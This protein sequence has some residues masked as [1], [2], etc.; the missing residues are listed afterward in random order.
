[1]LFW[2]VVLASLIVIPGVLFATGMGMIFWVGGLA[3]GPQESR[4]PK[5]IAGWLAM[6]WVL[7]SASG[8]FGVVPLWRAWHAGDETFEGGLQL[9]VDWLGVIGGI[10]GAIAA[11]RAIGAKGRRR[12]P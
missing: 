2:L 12:K 5:I 8:A 6:A 3:G 10:G 1:M 7:A 11:L 4:A 9:F